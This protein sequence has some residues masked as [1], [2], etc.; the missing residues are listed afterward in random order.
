RLVAMSKLAHNLEEIITHIKKHLYN[1]KKEQRKRKHH[2]R[3]NNQIIVLLH[4]LEV[5]GEAQGVVEL[6]QVV[7]EEDQVLVELVQVLVAGGSRGGRGR[8]TSARGKR[9]GRGSNGGRGASN[10]MYKREE[11]R[12]TLEHEYLQD[13][14]DQEEEQRNIAEMENVMTKDPLSRKVEEA[15]SMNKP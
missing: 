11:I 14:K 4:Q 7:A 12:Q 15:Q 6:V 5:V 2:A 3:K 8:S 13:L 10:A 9:G 1:L